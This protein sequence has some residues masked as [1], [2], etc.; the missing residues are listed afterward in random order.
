[1]NISSL[2]SRRAM[3]GAGFGASLFAAGHARYAFAATP[4]DRRL[5]VI[6]L[7]GALDGLSVIAPYGD[8][9][10]AAA[11]Q[12]LTLSPGAGALKL[13]GLFALND[14]LPF[15]ADE[16]AAGSALG[17]HAVATPYRDRS[18][19][20][21]QNVM[22]T[23]GSAPYA[24]ASGWLN[25]AIATLPGWRPSDAIAVAAT[26]PTLLLGPAKAGAYSVAA[27]PDLPADITARLQRLY[28]GDAQLAAAF[29]EAQVIAAVASETDIAD[30][31]MGRR[32]A[33][34]LTA[35]AMTA[36]QLMRAADGPRITVMERSGWDSHANQPGLLKVGLGDLNAALAA[37]KSGLGPLWAKTAVVCITE[38]GRTVRVNGTNGT[39]HGTA[40]AMLLVGGAVRGGRIL[41]DWPGL[42]AG[43]LHEGRDL[44]PT[45]DMR[46][47]LAGVLR[48]QVGITDAALARNVFSDGTAVTVR[49]GLIRA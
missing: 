16:Y 24:Q 15:V 25:R 19:F 10:Y 47:I 12:Q 49:D 22:E 43:N 48:D 17:I 33:A 23:G 42:G 14:A 30:A 40:T 2:L 21:A 28:A 3:L 26:T 11:R 31:G 41:A 38:F 34:S 18:H 20:D 6:I 27:M 1:M 13:D 4:Q 46:A 39:D 37:L 44:K 9:A 45:T 5:V 35:T 36:A 7:R 8:P 32:G 29:S